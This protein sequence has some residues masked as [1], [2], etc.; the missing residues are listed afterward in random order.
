MFACRCPFQQRKGP[1]YHGSSMH[2]HDQLPLHSE[3][4][5]WCPRKAADRLLMRII[6]AGHKMAGFLCRR[7]S[8]WSMTCMRPNSRTFC[9][10]YVQGTAP[11]SGHFITML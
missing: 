9:M 2:S 4:C 10:P 7:S 5:S 1:V 6:L 8:T 11:R 3:K